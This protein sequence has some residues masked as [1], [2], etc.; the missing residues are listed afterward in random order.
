MV[1]NGTAGNGTSSSNSTSGNGTAPAGNTTLDDEPLDNEGYNVADHLSFC[2]REGGQCVC[3]G[4]VYFGMA[5]PLNW[6]DCQRQPSA[7]AANLLTHPYAM[8]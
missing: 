3:E 8:K 6:G 1:A 4:T 7:C 2:A 5:D